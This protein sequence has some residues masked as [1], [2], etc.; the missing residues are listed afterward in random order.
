MTRSA[1]HIPDSTEMSV[2]ELN[3]EGVMEFPTYSLT[4]SV[5]S[6]VTLILL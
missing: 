1:L 3:P 4:A 6:V 5:E 2:N